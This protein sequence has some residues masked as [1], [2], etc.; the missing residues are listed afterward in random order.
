MRTLTGTVGSNPTP[1]AT[2]LGLQ[3]K[4]TLVLIFTTVSLTACA[5]A[6]RT[7]PVPTIEQRSINLFPNDQIE[8][9]ER[10]L[11]VVPVDRQNLPPPVEPKPVVQTSRT[12]PSNHKDPVIETWKKNNH[13]R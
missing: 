7:F 6:T 11:L 4:K 9:K 8:Y 10:P 2:G 3:M 13:I 5:N 1:S 12:V